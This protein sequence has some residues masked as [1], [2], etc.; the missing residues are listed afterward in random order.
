MEKE[1][2]H[3]APITGLRVRADGK[4]V[5]PHGGPTARL[6]DT[7]KWASTAQLHGNPLAA[8]TVA[9]AEQTLAFVKAEVGYHKASVGRKDQDLEKD[10]AAA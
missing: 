6:W 2:D 5:A 8:E 1:I 7:D 9:R 10:N 4:Q 3:G